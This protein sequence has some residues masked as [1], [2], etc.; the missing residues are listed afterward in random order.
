[1]RLLTRERF[2]SKKRSFPPT[3]HPAQSVVKGDS[4]LQFCASHEGGRVQGGYVRKGRRR[5]EA[6]IWNE[7]SKVLS[8]VVCIFSCRQI[9]PAVL[10]E[11]AGSCVEPSERASL[12]CNG[13]ADLRLKNASVCVWWRERGISWGCVP[14]G[15]CTETFM[16]KKSDFFRAGWQRIILLASQ[17][18]L[19]I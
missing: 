15:S 12:M 14:V 18:K 16:L 3:Q 6:F 9:F 17:K 19:R 5:I 4:A 10:W 11:K 2:L 8:T 13:L 1:M 7:P